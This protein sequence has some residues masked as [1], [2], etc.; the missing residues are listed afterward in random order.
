[1]WSREAR[2][3]DKLHVS[4]QLVLYADGGVRRRDVLGSAPR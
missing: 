2:V 3:S 4:I 1:M